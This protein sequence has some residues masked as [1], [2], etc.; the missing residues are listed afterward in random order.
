MAYTKGTYP[1]LIGGVSE[2]VP[3]ARQPNQVQQQLNMLSDP[4]TGPRRRGGFEH[5]GTLDSLTGDQFKSEMY[6][7]GGD[8]Y[9]L[10]V[11]TDTGKALLYAVDVPGKAQGEFIKEVNFPYAVASTPRSIRFAKHGSGVII[12]NTEKVVTA[13][14][15]LPED[16]LHPDRMGYFYIQQGQLDREFEVLYQLGEAGDTHTIKWKT[17]AS[18]AEN[19]TPVKVATELHAI[20]NSHAVLGTAKGWA[21]YRTGAYVFSIAPAG[22]AHVR[23]QSSMGDNFVRTSN[24]SYISDSSQLPARLPAEAEGYVMKVGKHKEN[25]YFEWDHLNTRWNERAGYGLRKPIENLPWLF[26]LEAQELKSLRGEGRLSGDEDNAPDPFF[27]GKKLTGAG[28]FQGRLVLLCKE[29]VFFSSSKDELLWRKSASSLADDDPI[30]IAGVTSYGLSYKYAVHF[31]GDLLILSE[32]AQAMVPGNVVLTPRNA[33]LSIA[34]EYQMSLEAPPLHTGKSLIFAAPNTAVGSALWEM[35]PSEYTSRNLYAQDI[36][37]HVPNLYRGEVRYGAVLDAAGYLLSLDDSTTLK[38]HQ[39]MWAGPDKVHSSFSEWEVP[40][41]V[42]ELHASGTSF[43][44]FVQGHHGSV[45]LLRW[46]HTG[47]QAGGSLHLDRYTQLESRG[48]GVLRV[49]KSMYTEA[50]LLSE[51]FLIVQ[52]T[53]TGT[54]Y[55]TFP[56]DVVS[57]NSA[58]WD[59]YSPYLEVPA[60]GLVGA[61]MCYRSVFQPTAPVL[62]DQY[63]QPILLERAVFHTLSLSVQDTGTMAVHF[64]DA[65]RPVQVHEIT[66]YRLYTTDLDTGDAHIGSGTLNIPFRTDLRTS[67]FWLESRGPNDMWIT[68]IE[69]GYRHNQRFRR[70]VMQGSGED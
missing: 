53:A 39:Y 43:W 38:V 9:A 55:Y 11:R 5:F 41:K 40:D 68:G 15:A 46:Q 13:G 35:V 50:E 42:L 51:Q 12:L 69:Y 52:Y 16:Q 6:D 37:E 20:L 14:A 22:L 30:E 32:T 4:V 8:V 45:R 34:A 47:V 65:A 57:Y 25:S 3:Q 61:G 44:L 63:G 58:Y 33:S 7:I 36:T 2:Q 21:H 19:A 62:R 18:G 10:T 26:D 49:P 23:V 1:Q 64:K 56:E 31:M 66:P 28:S 70:V 59:V 54:P 67:E 17:P 27:I 48:N 24:N 60:G 29:Y